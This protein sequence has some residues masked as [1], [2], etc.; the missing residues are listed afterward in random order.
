L[1]L[2]SLKIHGILGMTLPGT[3]SAGR[4]GL[5]N[6]V[7]PADQLLSEAVRLAAVI[8]S[9]DRRAV[10]NLKRVYDEGALVPMGEGLTLERT[11][12][13]EHMREVSPGD[14]AARRAQVQARNREQASG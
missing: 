10:R 12:A 11:I 2:P 5:V 9:N 3:L 7:F 8:A 4:W 6:Q 14:I 13:V 1:R